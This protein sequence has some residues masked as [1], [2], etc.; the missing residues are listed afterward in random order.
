MLG[1]EQP[2]VQQCRLLLP[3]A[4][5]QP[6][7]QPGHPGHAEHQERDDGFAALLPHQDAEHDT[8]HAHHGQDRA[9]DVDPAGPGVGHV[10]D[11]LDARQDDR[12][13]D[14]LKD[15][16]DPPGQVGRD[17]TAEQRPDRGGDRGRGADQ[18]VDLRP[19]GSVEVAVDERLHRR[20]QQRGAQP[21]DQRPEDDDRGQAL[22]QRH[23]QGADGVTQQAQ[24]VGPLTPDE[25]AQLAADQ[26][27]RGG[28][29]CLQRDRRLDAAH[30]RAEIP[31]DGRDRH[32]H[33]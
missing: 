13:D 22:G 1:L 2:G 5:P 33:Q 29:E 14:G 8:T 6:V 19:G 11:Q 23:R 9:H 30:G 26:D 21:T 25:I 32:V 27:E 10:P 20:Q 12:D 18:G 4:A 17:E 3:G 31:N 24:H 28:H 15:E 16:P 7:D